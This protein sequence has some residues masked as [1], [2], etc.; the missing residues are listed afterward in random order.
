MLTVE[1]LKENQTVSEEPRRFGKNNRIEILDFL[2]GSAMVY[3]MLYHLLYDIDTFLDINIPFLY[4]RTFEFIHQIFLFLLFIV[5]GICTS[6]SRNIIKRG[7]EIF[8]IGSGLTIFTDLFLPDYV[9]VFGVLTFFGIMMMLCGIFRPL[10]D[11]MSICSSAAAAVICLILYSMLYR[12]DNGGE[13]NLFFTKITVDLPTDR[14][15]LYPIGIKFNGFE[16]A[17][18]FPV[19]PNGFIFLAGAFLS[20]IVAE[21]RLPKFFY[22]KIKLPVINFLGRYSLIVY[23]VHQPI[24]L[25]AVFL[26]KGLFLWKT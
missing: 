7:A 8:F 15:Y 6:F 16:S 24:L 21:R 4:G 3:V 5:S 20:K 23:I 14:L 13:I 12:F 10:L 18:Y 2:R 17:D 1:V 25:A 26:F 11:K 9:I 19:I 22:S